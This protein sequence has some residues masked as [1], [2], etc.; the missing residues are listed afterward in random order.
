MNRFSGVI[1]AYLVSWIPD[2]VYAEVAIEPNDANT[3]YYGRY[4]F[5]IASAAEFRYGYTISER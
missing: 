5:S 2:I 4:D 3:D 1:T